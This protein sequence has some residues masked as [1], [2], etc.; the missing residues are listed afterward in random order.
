MQLDKKEIFKAL[1]N[2]ALA[3][4]R[5]ELYAEIA[6]EEGLHYFAKILEETAHNELSHVRELMSILNLLGN[7]RS[8][9]STA[10]ANESKETEEIYPKLSGLAKADGDLNM[11]RLFQ[12]IGKIEERHKERF[13]KLETLLEEDSV[14]KRTKVIRWKCRTCGYIYEGLEPP[15]KCPGCQSSKESYEPEDFS[16]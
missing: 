6:H 3:R 2:E 4:C 9:L 1:Q 11:A 16:I 7:T 12:Q 13:E 5:Y 8:N 15:K 10:I 14:Y